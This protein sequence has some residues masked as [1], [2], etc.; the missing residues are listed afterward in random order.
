MILLPYT[1]VHQVTKGHITFRY[2]LIDD[3][4]TLIRINRR[5]EH[6]A[7]VWR[8]RLNTLSIN[9]EE[10]ATIRTVLDRRISEGH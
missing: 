8:E 2:S 5:L 3:L 6:I 10:T 9:R 1:L 4:M 7:N